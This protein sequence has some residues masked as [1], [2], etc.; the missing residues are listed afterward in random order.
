M[1]WAVYT[2]FARR[3]ADDV[4][5]E[6][7]SALIVAT[8][9]EVA[10]ADDGCLHAPGL[11]VPILAMDRKGASC[12]PFGLEEASGTVV[13]LAA[14]QDATGLWVQILPLRGF[15]GILGVLALRRREPFAPE[16]AEALELL[17]A[18]AA[19][20]CDFRR[21]QDRHERQ[22]D[23][24]LGLYD[25]YAQTQHQ[26][27]AE[28]QKVEAALGLYD[29]Y[30]QAQLQLRAEEQKVEAALGLYDLYEESQ[31]QLRAEQAK[32]EAALGLYDLYEAAQNQ[33]IEQEKDK[34]G[35]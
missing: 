16:A 7:L 31:N 15:S 8:A 20:A 33:L 26:L 4:S 14:H 17:V 6:T 35:L 22:L 19:M 18:M 21:T 28:E 34:Q 23:A 25:V 11:R 32:L 29:L 30:E 5:R 10:D 9:V 24:A 3:L 27:V 1:Q 2:T 13:P 12:E